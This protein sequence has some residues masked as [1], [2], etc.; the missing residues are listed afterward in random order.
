MNDTTIWLDFQIEE[1]CGLWLEMND[2]A[3]EKGILTIV[4]FLHARKCLLFT[5]VCNVHDNTKLT[6]WEYIYM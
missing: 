1:Y 6:D 5:H 2:G 4:P 3:W